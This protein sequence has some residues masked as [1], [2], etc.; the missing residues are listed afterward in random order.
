M[1]VLTMHEFLP[2]FHK[3]EVNETKKKLPI[4]WPSASKSQR[5]NNQCWVIGLSPRHK[6][7]TEIYKMQMEAIFFKCY[8]TLSDGQRSNQKSWFP[9]IADQKN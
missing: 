3:S 4:N 6:A 9:L 2:K 8:Q 1:I 7:N 5:K